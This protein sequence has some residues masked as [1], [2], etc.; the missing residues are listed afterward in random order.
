MPLYSSHLRA[1]EGV[2]RTLATQSTAGP[3]DA[4]HTESR[5]ATACRLCG[6]PDVAHFAR[7]DG[8]SVGRC[9]RCRCGQVLCATSPDLAHLDEAS[10]RYEQELRPGKAEACLLLVEHATDRLSGVEAVLDVGC[11]EGKFLDLLKARGVATAGIEISPRAAEV[12]RAKGHSICEG[13]ATEPLVRGGRTFDVVTMWDILEHLAE[14]GRALRHLLGVLRPGGHL[15]V[16]T[17]MMGSLYDRLGRFEH[18]VTAGRRRHLLSLCFSRDHVF[19]FHPKGVV[20]ALR[21]L[22][23]ADATAR[24]LTMLSLPDTAYAGGLLTRSWT[25][26]PAL[27]RIISRLGVRVACLARF[28]NKIL[29][30]ARAPKGI[31][32]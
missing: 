12:A 21:E 30:H 4:E 23:F 10:D 5:P 7:F 15:L 25:G 18:M 8:L 1:S 26:R 17:P 32:P 24:P 31:E 2:S 29:I 28:H 13:S 11:G 19:R 3:E 16:V 20:D 9:R 22:G 14:P 6:G 27:D